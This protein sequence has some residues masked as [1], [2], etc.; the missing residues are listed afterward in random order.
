MK[1]FQPSNKKLAAQYYNALNT[2]DI[3]RAIELAARIPP[4]T[5]LPENRWTSVAMYVLDSALHFSEAE[6]QAVVQQFI[7]QGMTDDHLVSLLNRAMLHGH[8]ETALYILQSV[9]DINLDGFEEGYCPLHSSLRHG[10]F[11]VTRVLIER[12]A[13]VHVDSSYGC[14][15]LET[16]VIH[17]AP[18]DII[19]Q[20]VDGGVDVNEFSDNPVLHWVID[21]GDFAVFSF[22]LSLPQLDINARGKERKTAMHLLCG[23]H[24]NASFLKDMAVRGGVEMSVPDVD[25]HTPVYYAKLSALMALQDAFP[26]ERL[27]LEEALRGAATRGD[28]AAIPYLLSQGADVNVPDA[29]GK[30]PLMLAA[31]G[32]RVDC[33]RLLLAAD[34]DL[35]RVCAEG[36]TA[37]FYAKGDEVQGLLKERKL[38]LPA[39]RQT[40]AHGLKRQDDYSIQTVD[41]S[42]LATTFNFWTQQVIVR[43]IVHGGVAEFRRRPAL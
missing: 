40:A 10:S 30:T 22:L 19:R 17:G 23:K 12:G 6:T 32:G 31:K 5:P 25:G 43:D 21:R 26:D 16:A 14:P 24:F 2:G 42:G 3:S 38:A 36:Y 11:R 28:A 39:P 7:R 9:K 41:A 35:R 18:V 20:L 15:V 33:V 29:T 1:F 13:D 27:N 37:Q 8:E 34:A 4:E